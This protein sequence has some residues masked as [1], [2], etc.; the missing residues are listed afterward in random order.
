MAGYAHYLKLGGRSRVHFHGEVPSWLKRLPMRTEIVVRRRSLFGDDPL[1][2][3]DADL[4]V[5]GNWPTVEV[6]RWP[7]RASS[8]ERAI[9]D[10]LDELPR[11]A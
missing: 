9:L 6:W 3:D 7:L 2:I 1:G 10:A 5:A 4:D 11:N 8:P